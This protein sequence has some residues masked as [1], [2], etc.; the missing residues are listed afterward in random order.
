MKTIWSKDD[1][2]AVVRERR[3]ALGLSQLAL[4]HEAGLPDGYTGKLEASAGKANSRS[5]GW[6]SLP[7][8]LSALGLELA[9]FLPL[10]ST[11]KPEINQSSSEKIKNKFIVRASRGGI[12]RAALL[13]QGKRRAIARKAALKRWAKAGKRK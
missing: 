3:S 7:K 13:D 12:A 1:L 11:G 4:D 2:V 5:I 10:A 9:A 6:E 8:I